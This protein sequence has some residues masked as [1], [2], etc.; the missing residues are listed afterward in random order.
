MSSTVY[1]ADFNMPF[2]SMIGYLV[3]LSLAS[4]PATI[5]FFIILGLIWAI[6]G[7][8]IAALVSGLVSGILSGVLGPLNLR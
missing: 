4:I 1:V 3:K 5:I 2:L 6:F 8:A 7:A